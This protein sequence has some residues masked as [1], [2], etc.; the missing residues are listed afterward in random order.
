MIK[1]DDSDIKIAGDKPSES[2]ENSKSTDMIVRHEAQRD[3][4]NIEK[5][6]EL[7]ALM[8]SEVLSWTG[9]SIG[10]TFLTDEQML[11]VFASTV[12]FDL[13]T[14]E[15][16]LAVTALTEFYKE[17][18]KQS[19]E[20]YQKVSG[21]PSFSFYYICMKD[22]ENMLSCIGETFAMLCGRENYPALID[23]GCS[24][25]ERFLLVVKNHAESLE[26]VKI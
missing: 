12:G 9:S 20:F 10:Q 14:S 24:L 25:Y 5:A 4:G 16:V 26:F 11:F 21:S 2:I 19:P 3:A 13:Y 18:E 7:G 15:R 1:Y 8:A 23:K 6:A 17:L 22:K